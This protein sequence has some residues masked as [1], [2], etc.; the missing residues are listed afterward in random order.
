MKTMQ[1]WPAPEGPAS[2]ELDPPVGAFW[3]FTLR[4]AAG[5][6][7][8]PRLKVSGFVTAWDRQTV[9]IARQVSPTGPW[10]HFEAHE[11]I[12][13]LERSRIVGP[14]PGRQLTAASSFRRYR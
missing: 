5:G 3:V 4:P 13:V 1:V 12:V 2:R 11:V 9:S 8:G 10:D 6:A 14:A 7:R